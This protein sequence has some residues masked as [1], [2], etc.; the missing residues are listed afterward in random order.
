MQSSHGKI[1]G[2]RPLRPLATWALA[3]PQFALGSSSNTRFRP[4]AGSSIGSL[5]A[6]LR[7][8]RFRPTCRYARFRAFC[9][10]PHI[11]RGERPGRLDPILSICPE[12]LGSWHWTS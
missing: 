7:G 5:L 6:I 4:L 12:F 10:L 1:R 2:L 11:R 3:Y 8:T 9:P